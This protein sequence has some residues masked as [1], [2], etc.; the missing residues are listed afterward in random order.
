MKDIGVTVLRNEYVR[1]TIGSEH[2]I[3]AGVDDKNGPKDMKTPR[4]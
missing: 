4:N 3:L 2:I 1:L